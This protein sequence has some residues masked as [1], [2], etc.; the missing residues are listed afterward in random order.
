M[1][2]AADWHHV[3][4]QTAILPIKAYR[5]ASVASKTMGIRAIGVGWRAGAGRDRVA[6]ASSND[7][8]TLNEDG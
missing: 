7:T 4:A 3:M 1:S 2:Q 8:R 6:A 5:K